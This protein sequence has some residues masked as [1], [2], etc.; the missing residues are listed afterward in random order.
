MKKVVRGG[1]VAVLVSSGFGAGWYTWNNDFPQLLFHPDI[2]RKVEEN[3]LEDIT[4][5]WLKERKI[6]KKKDYV[7]T[8]GARDLNIQWLK[9]GTRFEIEE[10]DGSESLRTLEDLILVA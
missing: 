1:K 4:E 3:K 6:I 8:G 9:E 2:V 10:Y 5:E 7:Y